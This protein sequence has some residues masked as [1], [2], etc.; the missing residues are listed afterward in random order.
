[1]NQ[2]SDTV[3]GGHAS[4]K[5]KDG[6]VTKAAGYSRV[7]TLNGVEFRLVW[8]M[9]YGFGLQAR[10]EYDFE[11]WVDVEVMENRAELAN[12]ISDLLCI[13][14]D[15]ESYTFRKTPDGGFLHWV[16]TDRM[17]P[18]KNFGSFAGLDF[19]VYG[20]DSL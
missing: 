9:K 1:M 5:I 10:V 2:S 4:F 11:D 17:Y 14:F 18:L 19:A 20:G 16:E 7:I 13:G 8:S 15:Q 12:A 6:W 3:G